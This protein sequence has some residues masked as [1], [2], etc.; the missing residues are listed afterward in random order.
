MAPRTRPTA[1]FASRAL[2]LARFVALALSAF[3]GPAV[4]QQAAYFP[5]GTYDAAVPTPRQVLG[6]DIGERFTSHARLVA[7]LESVVAASKRVKLVRYGESC[8]GRPLLLLVVTSEENHSRLDNLKESVLKLADPRKSADAGA[9][10]ELVRS[11]RVFVWL[12]YGVHGNESSSAEAAM[13]TVYQLA[14]GTDAGTTQLLDGAVILVDPLLNPDGRDRYVNWFNSVVG[15]KP[16]PDPQSAEHDEPWP[17]GRYNHYLFDLNRDWAWLTQRETLAR[18]ARYVQWMPQVHVDFHEMGYESTYFFFPADAPINANVPQKTVEWA[19]T[20]GKGNAAAFDA[21]GWPYY[22]AESFDLYYPGYGDSWPSLHGAIGMTYEQAGHSSAGLVVKRRDDT[23]L[24]LRDRVAHHFTS[25]IA[26]VRTAVENRES[27][28]R[29]FHE[30]R[31]SAIEEGE[32]ESI[33]EYLIVPGKDPERTA[34]LI[35]LLL[36]Q[37]VEVSRAKQAFVGEKVHGYLN[38]QWELEK[39]PEGTYV[40]S[41]RQPAKRLAKALLEP[42]A[43]VTKLYFYD[44]SAWSLPLA[45]GVRAYWTEV[46]TTVEKELLSARPAVEGRIEGATEGTVYYLLPWETNAAPRALYQ[47][48]SE[49]LLARVA[50]KTF[51]LDGR[52]F[53]RGTV[54]VPVSGNPSDLRDRLSKIA[55]ENHLVLTAAKTG[56]TEKGINLGSDHVEPLRLPAIAVATGEGVSATSYGA[57]WFLLEQ[58]YRIPFTP[59]PLKTLGD[60]D[61]GRYNV[62]VFPDDWGGYASLSPEVVK[63]IKD[64]VERG[65][66]FIGIAGGAFFATQETSKLTPVTM[67]DTEE[68]TEKPGGPKVEE[69][70]PAEA[71]R[72]ESAGA[73][74]PKEPSPAA[75]AK[76]A[77]KPR[78]RMKIEEQEAEARKRQIPGT[79]LAVDLDPAHPLAFGYDERIHVLKAGPEA[80]NWSKSGFNVGSFVAGKVS[81]YISKENEEKLGKKAYLV[82]VPLGRGHVVLYADDPTFRLFW[83]GLTRLFL[84]GIFFLSKP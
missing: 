6:Y 44:V 45:Y 64:W 17:G 20:F 79:I 51:T 21:F 84:N 48:L 10:T 25:G 12:S 34:E 42:E 35:D 63:K 78:E 7:Y 33:K 3:A 22:T 4:A 46:A 53:G 41:M 52:E 83:K 68:K 37:G 1:P 57:V 15:Q 24:T 55:K 27:L 11:A 62:L 14:A 2:R 47:L 65:G 69:S 59:L 29:D 80:F 50:K 31:K 30:F 18:I 70:E 81:G 23:L 39:F 67:A 82:E 49:G 66:T 28:L 36:R 61:L 43:E 58:E 74:E 13:Q 60:A 5:G 19:K 26:T 8:E 72:D 54:V 38:D 77:K 73:D 76:K 32:K 71:P 75:E 9:V 56:L 16:N 40:V